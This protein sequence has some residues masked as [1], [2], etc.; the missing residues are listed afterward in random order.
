[1]KKNLLSFAWDILRNFIY[2]FRFY[3]FYIESKID[4][5]E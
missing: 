2:K 3:I 1:M 4:R 5:D